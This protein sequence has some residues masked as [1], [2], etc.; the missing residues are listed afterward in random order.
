MVTS[1]NGKILK[2]LLGK[3]CSRLSFLVLIKNDDTGELVIADLGMSDELCSCGTYLANRA[4]GFS[5][6][7]TTE[8]R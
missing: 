5:G 4:C 8:L 6:G 1:P 2:S 3:G 7:H